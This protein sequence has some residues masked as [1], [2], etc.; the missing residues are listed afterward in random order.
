MS[1]FTKPML[2]LMHKTDANHKIMLF[3]VPAR[4]LRIVAT[5]DSFMSFRVEQLVITNKDPHNPRGSW[6]TLS[7]HS[8]PQ[9]GAAWNVACQAAAEAQQTLLHKLQQRRA[10]AQPQLLV[11]A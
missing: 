11:P 4:A 3:M 6:N 9:P 10:N 1:A 7:T 5:D 8:G 2:D